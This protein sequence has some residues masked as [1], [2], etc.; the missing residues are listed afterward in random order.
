MVGQLLSVRS[1]SAG[2]TIATAGTRER[3]RLPVFFAT[4]T[5]T[6]LTWNEEHCTRRATLSRAPVPVLILAVGRPANRLKL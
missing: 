4:R 3:G 6:F 2:R 1:S 5:I